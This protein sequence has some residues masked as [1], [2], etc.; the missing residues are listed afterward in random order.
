M[1]LSQRKEK[2]LAAV[3][4]HYIKTGEPVGSKTLLSAL[5]ITVSSATIRNEMAELVALG[6]LEQPHTSAGRIPTN[7]GYRYYVDRLMGVRPL[8]ESVKRQ[9]EAG[10]SLKNASPEAILAKAS[11]FL[12]DMTDCAAVSTT[13]SGENAT[14]KRVEFVPVGTRTGMIVLLTST[15]VIKS[16]V[17]RSDVDLNSSMIEKFYNIVKSSFLGL[18]LDEIDTATLQTLVAS[19]GMDALTMIPFVSAVSELAQEAMQT[20]VMLG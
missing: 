17:C 16:K 4:E 14:I 11:E 1:E 5:D 18:P 12:A 7:E 3:V 9:I 10:V 20:M 13:P 6:F 15:G 19:M 2:I 8:D